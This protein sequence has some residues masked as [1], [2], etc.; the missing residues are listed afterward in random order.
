MTQ[1]K[2]NHSQ[3]NKS[4]KLHVANAVDES[5]QRGFAD[6]E[7]NHSQVGFDESPQRSVCLE[8]TPPDEEIE[9]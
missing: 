8:N 6:T 3:Q 5:R 7:D 2:D 4:G 1:T 9:E